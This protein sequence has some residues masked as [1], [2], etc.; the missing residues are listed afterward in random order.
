MP[1]RTV[2]RSAARASSAV[3]GRA[4]V[5]TA[6]DAI[7]AHGGLRLHRRVPVAELLRDAISLQAR[8]GGRR[9]HVATR[10]RARARV[11]RIEGRVMSVR[12]AATGRHSL[13]G[14]AGACARGPRSRSRSGRRSSP[15]TSRRATSSPGDGAG[16]AVRREPP[17][18]REALGSLVVA[19]SDQEG[20]G[21]SRRKLR[22]QR[23][24]RLTQLACSA[25]RWTPSSAS[26]RSTSTSSPPCAECSRSRRVVGGSPHRTTP[27]SATLQEHRRPSADRRPSRTR[28]SCPTTATSTSPSPTRPATVCWRRSSRRSTTQPDRPSSSASRPRSAARPSSSTSP[29]SALFAAVRRRTPRTPWRST[30]SYVL[31]YSSET[32]GSER[33]MTARPRTAP[34]STRRRHLLVVRRPH[35][36]DV[37]RRHG[38]GRHQDRAAPRGRRQGLGTAVP[39]R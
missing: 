36:V 12:K 3:A 32:G 5:E 8:A 9:L 4:A 27:S 24:P 28:T 11:A 6:I 33:I 37:P 34:R 25:S 29:S 7:Q 22:Q 2:L 31:R 21:R 1:A 23:H 30:S 13:P 16:P 35:R 26:A 38:R 15:A 10:R 19:G 39:Q 18:V 14:P 20:P 17:T